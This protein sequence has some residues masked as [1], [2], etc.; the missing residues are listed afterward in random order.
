MY[1]LIIEK[2]SEI[3]RKFESCID[4]V[5]KDE[6]AI[7][8]LSVSNKVMT[9]EYYQWIDSCVN[10]IEKNYKKNSCE[11]KKINKLIEK[12]KYDFRIG[13]KRSYRYD[14]ECE[15]EFVLGVINIFIELETMEKLKD[16]EETLQKESPKNIIGI[17]I[18][19]F[20]GKKM[21]NCYCRY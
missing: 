18:Q 21:G 5:I 10:I 15:L 11:Y 13:V 7:K 4:T 1:E 17:V 20:W 2:G 8:S 12:R 6:N 3:K 14:F 9:E 16:K 19:T